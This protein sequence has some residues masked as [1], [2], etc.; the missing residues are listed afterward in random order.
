MELG[1][2]GIAKLESRLHRQLAVGLAATMTLAAMEN[3]GVSTVVPLI[4]KQLGHIA[5][6]GWFFS[7][8]LLMGLIGA[9]VLGRLS[10]R[11]D[12]RVILVISLSF[13]ALGL[14]VIAVAPSMYLVILGRAIQ[15]FGAGATIVITYLVINRVFPQAHKPQ[16]LAMLAWTWVVPSFVVPPLAAFMAQLL[17]WRA[18]FYSLIP[19]TLASAYLVVSSLSKLDQNSHKDISEVSS[20]SGGNVFLP[21]E[22][23]LGIGYTIG[24]AL[25]L[26]AFSQ[27][28][29]VHEV[30]IGLLGGV[31][32]L[33]CILLLVRITR[34]TSRTELTKLLILRATVAFAFFGIEPFLPLGLYTLKH[35]S[36]PMA[37]LV[38]TSSALGW[39]VG[40][41][42]QGR[43]A[44]RLPQ[45]QRLII[46]SG[47]IVLALVVLGMGV[48]SANSS[49]WIIEVAWLAAGA[50][51]GLAYPTITLM[52]MGLGTRGDEGGV[53]SLLQML[54]ASGAALGAGVLGAVL[55]GRSH[56]G[57]GLSTSTMTTAVLISLVGATVAFFVAIS[58]ATISPPLNDGL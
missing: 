25:C 28:S 1:L 58:M 34:T 43:F 15:G 11:T 27:V 26:I 48:Y 9:V 46:G 24:V 36:L 8:F 29:L 40:S 33:V 56:G 4:G 20:T 18:I 41:W 5:L 51:I 52:G 44:N 3:I 21:A 39:S 37:G 22:V 53:T 45:R 57:G 14:A 2:L 23:A 55:T 31:L 7:S 19:V 32:A 35:L 10:T 54:D 13:F 42:L 12:L 30:L 17:G 49:S 50:G 47:I 16:M 38:L 6:Y